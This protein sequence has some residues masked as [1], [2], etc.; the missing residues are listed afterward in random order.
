MMPV[1]QWLAQRTPEIVKNAIYR[2]PIDEITKLKNLG[3]DGYLFLGKWAKHMEMAATTL[4]RVEFAGPSLEIWYLTGNKFWYQTVFCAWS[5]ANYSKRNIAL[6]LV[7]DGTLTELQINHMR[8]IFSDVNVHTASSCDSTINKLLPVEKFPRLRGLRSVYPHI[9]KLTDVH[10]GSTGKKLVL[11]SD[12]LFFS[13]PQSLVNWLESNTVVSPIYMKDV[14]ECYGYPRPFLERLAGKKLP[15]RVNVGICGLHSDTMD[16]GE[17]EYWCEELQSRFGN[18]YY[19]EQ[20]LVAM[21]VARQ[22]GFQVPSEDYIVLPS[23]RQVKNKAGILQHYVAESKKH[24]FKF[25]WQGV[26]CD[27][28]GS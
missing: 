26:T 18:S 12:M 3:I 15:Q 6:R 21:L 14:V 22:N 19:L 2:R 7:D 16:W 25:G 5:L 24:Y 11:D 4:P 8:R 23:F 28:I 9:R 27:V 1:R 13:C 20:A 17:L 10:V